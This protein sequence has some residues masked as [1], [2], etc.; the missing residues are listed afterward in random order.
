MSDTAYRALLARHSDGEHR[1]CECGLAYR[2]AHGTCPGGCSK[3]RDRARDFI[4]EQ[5][6]EA[7]NAVKVQVV[8]DKLLGRQ[9]DVGFPGTVWTSGSMTHPLSAPFIFGPGVLIGKRNGP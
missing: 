5:I 6:L 7:E 2:G 1:P 9:P 8:T 4:A 3:N